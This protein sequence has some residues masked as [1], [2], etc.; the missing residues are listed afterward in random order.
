MQV[1]TRSIITGADRE[2]E[3]ELRIVGQLNRELD[4]PLCQR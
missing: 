3:L 1:T 4:R 2:I